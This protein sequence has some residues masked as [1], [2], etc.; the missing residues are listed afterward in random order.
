MIYQTKQTQGLDR[1]GLQPSASDPVARS[2]WVNDR[3]Q[4]SDQFTVFGFKRKIKQERKKERKRAF[5]CLHFL[6]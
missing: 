3:T 4:K 6:H 2:Q 5:I 1:I